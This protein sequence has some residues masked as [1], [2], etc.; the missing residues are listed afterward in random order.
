MSSPSPAAANFPAA[1]DP[2]AALHGIHPPAPIGI[3]PPAPGWWAVAAV[4]AIGGALALLA[5]R[6]HR[7]SIAR[8]A[9]CE[10]DV[11]AARALDLHGLAGAVSE[12]L[13]RVALV[14]FG[15][16]AARLH[17]SGWQDFLT[18]HAPHGRRG[19]AAAAF[20]TD[21]GRTVALAPYAPPGAIALAVAGPQVDRQ[22]LLDAAR[23]WIRGN[24]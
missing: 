6:R 23:A 4:V 12:L 14:R 22:A 10:L 9:L 3:W 2:L 17:G 5:I 11:L 19:R 18:A 1:A 21:L 15:R 8:H 13:R 7:A 16:S 20:S 24:L